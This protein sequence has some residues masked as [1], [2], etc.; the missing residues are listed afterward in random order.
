MMKMPFVLA[1]LLALA[2]MMTPRAAA[3]N[4]FPTETTADY[5]LACMAV[6]GETATALRQCSCSIDVIASL[7]SYDDYT[8][9][10]TVL[11]M[12]QVTGEGMEMFRNMPWTSAMVDKLRNAQAEAEVRCFH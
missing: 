11:R 12:R 7:I 6:N 5:V 9:A 10:E 4:D 1:A 3:A 2:G 8:E